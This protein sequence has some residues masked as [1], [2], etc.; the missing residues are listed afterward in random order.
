MRIWDAWYAGDADQ[1]AETYQRGDGRTR[2]RPAQ[3]AGGLVGTLA[4]F[5]WGRP[6][7]PNQHRARLHVPLATDI[8]EASAS[9]LF[10]DPPR[11]ETE[12]EA[13][14]KRLDRVL[15]TAGTHASLLESAE[16]CSALG[17]SYLRVAWDSEIADAPWLDTVDA[18]AGIPDYRWGRLFAVT[19]WRTL[20]DPYR[21][22]ATWRHLERHEVGRILHGLYLGDSQSLG[23]MMPLEE[24][25]ETER[26]GALVDGEGAV[27]TG[28]KRLTAAYI[29]N[30]RP[31]PL[32]RGVPELA[33]L[34]RSDY[35]GAEPVLDAL[36][37]TYSSWMRDVK[38]AKAR[39]MVPAG[40]LANQGPGKGATFDE[41]QEVFQELN[42][43][44]AAGGTSGSQITLHQFAIRVEE[45][46][47]TAG[48]LTRRAL[49]RAGL[50]PATLGRDDD[51]ASSSSRTATEVVA[52]TDRSE[53][54]R[55]K[56]ARYHE[57]ALEPIAGALLDVDATHFRGRA[58]EAE[59]SLVWPDRSQPDPET[60][61]RTA[62]SLRRAEAASTEVIVRTAQPNLSGE[63]LDAEVARVLAESGRLV[64]DP[65][66]WRGDDH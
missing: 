60:L 66:T 5:F 63:E 61:A 53:L 7:P 21:T 24:H 8:A 48:E 54:T 4:R 50:S 59:V 56:K 34:G 30:V 29:P 41:D 32:W 26:L 3:H 14:Q 37:E 42:M 17:G 31:A 20:P 52:N 12:L 18:D 36:D 51:G 25:P 62:E 40:Y 23:R 44:G 16:T 6:N 43:M 47:A 35:A 55:K 28:S 33:E 9:L 64:P 13:G 15:N 58:A 49:D 2:T 11:F 1:L 45:H 19:F 10:A 22:G 57:A 46:R 27:M 65:A 38:L 39:I